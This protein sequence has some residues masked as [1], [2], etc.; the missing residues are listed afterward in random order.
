MFYKL[1]HCFVCR[2]PEEQGINKD[3]AAPND[4]T[5]FSKNLIKTA[6]LWL[7]LLFN[8]HFC[9]IVRIQFAKMLL[10]AF[11]IGMMLPILALDS[12]N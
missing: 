10:T 6:K 8:C 9:F 3:F 4:N 12:N 7:K 1:T 11:F 2:N 5:E